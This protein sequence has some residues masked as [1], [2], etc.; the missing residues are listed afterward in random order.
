MYVFILTFILYRIPVAF[1]EGLDGSVKI[2]VISGKS[3]GVESP[4]RP[5][6]G[7]WYFHVIFSKKSTIFQHLRRSLH[8]LC[9]GQ[10]DANSC[11]SCGVDILHL[12]LEGIHHY[13][14]QYNANRR[15]QHYCSLCRWH[16]NRSK[17]DCHWG[18]HRVC[19]SVYFFNNCVWDHL[20]RAN[21]SL[22][23]LS[24]RQFSSMVHS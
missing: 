7:C 9:P 18:R 5:L 6:G 8:P 21:R 3:H 13:R 1:P 19:F 20:L 23:S 17:S 14:R 15:F 10:T 24:T 11:T 16:A 2:R 4:V 12:H 22:E